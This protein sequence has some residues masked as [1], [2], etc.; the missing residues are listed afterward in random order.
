VWRWTGAFGLAGAIIF[1][2]EVPLWLVGFPVPA[3][4]NAAAHAQYLSDHRIVALTRVLFDMVLYVT[5]M[6]FFAGFR[7][8]IRRSRP[9]YE[10]LGTLV[11]G[12]AITWFAVTLVADSFEGAAALD[13]LGG[14]E[15]SAVR[16]LVEATLLIYNGSIAFI[17]MALVL[18]S[19]GYAILSTG[20]LP[21]WEGSLGCA[22]ALLCVIAVPSMYAPVLDY[23]GFYN[24]AGWGPAVVANIPPLVWLFAVSISLL[25]HDASQRAAMR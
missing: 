20:L 18:A 11:F 21:K 16:A 1:L 12:S 2:L 14:A 7:H 22:G 4:N 6:I 10:W 3:I 25:K 5:L 15:P 23:S 19:A 17:T 8:L 24:A 13:T 9:D